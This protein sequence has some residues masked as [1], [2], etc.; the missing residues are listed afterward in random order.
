MGN[1]IHIDGNVS[2]PRIYISKMHN[3]QETQKK[4]FKTNWR[5]SVCY[6][7]FYHFGRLEFEFWYKPL[8]LYNDNERQ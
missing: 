4:C 8:T 6:F 2:K 5:L 3:V 1:I 7:Y